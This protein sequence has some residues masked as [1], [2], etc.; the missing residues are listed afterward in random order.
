MSI[1]KNGL[2]LM[3]VYSIDMVFI[4][5][6]TPLFDGIADAIKLLFHEEPYYKC[7]I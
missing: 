4:A 3:R 1:T 7:L 2:H 5:S 6:V